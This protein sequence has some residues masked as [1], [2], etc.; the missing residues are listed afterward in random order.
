MG[1]HGQVGGA[2]GVAPLRQGAKFPLHCAVEWDKL[3]L[4]DRT[5]LSLRDQAIP[6]GAIIWEVIDG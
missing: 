6:G 1:D 4:P 3:Q 2:E 5:R